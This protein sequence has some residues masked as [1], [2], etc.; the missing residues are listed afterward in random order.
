MDKVNGINRLILKRTLPVV[1]I[2]LVA[3]SAIRAG[4]NY[5][6]DVL[7]IKKDS[8]FIIQSQLPPLKTALWSLDK[9]QINSQLQGLRNYPHIVYV[10]IVKDN[11]VLF[12]NGKRISGSS[13]QWSLPLTVPFNNRDTYIGTLQLQIET[14]SLLKQ[15]FE[16]TL[17]TMLFQII[18]VILT[19]MIVSTMYKR[20]VIR[21]IENA[22][23]YFGSFEI[24]PVSKDLVLDKT[25]VGD[26]VD[27]LVT[28]FNK[29]QKK[30]SETYQTIGA[31]EEKYR[32]LAESTSAISW[33]FDIIADRWTYVAPQA[34]NM[35]GYT[36]EEWT[37]LAWWRDKIHPEDRLWA[38]T[39]CQKFTSRG[40][41]HSFEYRFI[42]R[43][44]KTVWVN[45]SV[46]VEMR[47]SVPVIMRG[48][49]ID[50]TE[51]KMAEQL[52]ILDRDIFS[53]MQD[54]RDLKEQMRDVVIM[55][56]KTTEFDA[57]GIRLKAD[58]NFPYFAEV[59]F[60][61]DLLL[62]ENSLIERNKNGGVC[63]VEDGKVCLECTC[64]LVIT[65]TIKQGHSLFSPRGS[66]WTNDSFPLLDIPA[67]DEPRHNPRNECIHHEYASI[68]LI[69]VRDNE[70]IIGLIQLNHHQKGRLNLQMIEH[71]E[72]IATHI[73]TALVQMH[74]NEQNKAL[75]EQLRQ[76]QKMEAIGMLAGGV[77]HDFNNILTV[78]MGYANLLGLGGALNEKQREAAEQI[79]SSSEKAAQLTSGLLAF[80][81][82]QVLDV[83][84]ADLNDIV[85]KV[86]KF[87]GRV[88]GEDVKLI[89]TQHNAQLPVNVDSGQIEQVLINLA[90]NARDAMP[91]G[92]MLTIETWLQ[93]IDSQFIHSHGYGE[94]G[95]YALM[96][97]SDTG[98]GMDEETCSKIFEPFFTTKVVGK[99]TGLGMAIVYGIVKQHSGFIN[100]YSEPGEGT[101]FKV[102]L[103]ISASENDA[104]NVAKEQSVPPRGTETILLA[105]DDA[106]VNKLVTTI[107]TQFG[108]EVIQAVDGQDAIDKFIANSENI[109][110]I[111]MDMIMPNKNGKEAY[112]EIRQIRPN[113]K[114]LYSSGYTADFIQ[115]RGVKEEGAELIMKPVQPM[116]LL[117]KIR[118]MLD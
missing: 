30:L 68:A 87:L 11:S 38:P 84:Q 79:I 109:K 116:E 20:M 77:A 66:F 15:G 41:N 101:A 52:K 63:R 17:W 97:I 64:G 25:A 95:L 99:G 9:D 6:R 22:A 8:E 103:P 23:D 4:I 90:T 96:T 92:G 114:V 117:R 13:E 50:I 54:S 80:S 36:P 45:D 60:P 18:S 115:S 24:G 33:E 70:Q 12:E 100:V 19:V 62:K 71:L 55:L 35:L 91:N 65:G 118:E 108:Y 61:S 37:D 48:I 76:S 58:E 57:V 47:D 31:E 32:L 73:G 28:S 82:K 83:R 40:E 56:K 69:P 10:A 53:L 86:Q 74:A 81:R 46:S 85:H 1:L 7:R 98:A 21:H 67:E 44:G 51:H 5:Y 34:E 112:E 93:H 42:A 2:L 43:S 102:Y 107:L 105:E 88:I 49:L 26:E 3:L 72:D 39:Y 106:T 89:C 14:G 78:I 16:N 29:M 27:L 75:E 110:L 111:L 104:I 59:G 94:P 113:V